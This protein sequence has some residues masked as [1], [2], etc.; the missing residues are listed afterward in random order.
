MARV[1]QG[2][3]DFVVISPP[4]GS[5]SRSNWANDD[6]PRP[7]RDRTPPWGLPNL[8]AAQQKRDTAGNEFIHFSIRT[9]GLVNAANK[10]GL[11]VRCLLEHPKDLGRTN[12]GSPA[13]IW[14]LPTLREIGSASDFVTVA[15]H[16]CQYPRIDRKK[17]IRRMSYVKGFSACGYVGW[18][19]FD[20][21]DY[22]TGP[23]PHNCGHH[24]KRRMIGRT[25]RGGFHTSPTAAYP[26]GMCAFIA[27]TIFDDWFNSLGKTSYGM[28][29]PS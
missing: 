1:E 22:Y 6:G 10:K 16:Q 12:R 14:Q 13:S 23:L 25:K 8:R 15:G 18:P 29:F 17:P 27:K 7:I 20:A 24:H 26:D 9:I 28:G 5:W 2:D 19:T 11:R 4:C 3:F 21:A